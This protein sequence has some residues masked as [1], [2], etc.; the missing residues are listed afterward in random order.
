MRDPKQFFDFAN[1]KRK[2]VSDPSSMQFGGSVGECPTDIC[3]LFA[4]MFESIYKS[5]LLLLNSAAMG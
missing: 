1:Y 4:D 2:T 3:E 5:I